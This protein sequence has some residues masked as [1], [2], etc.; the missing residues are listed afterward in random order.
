MSYR[1][2]TDNIFP[3]GT[4]ISAKANPDQK[5]IIKRYYQRIY[6]CTAVD[7]TEK[8]ELAY[9]QRELIPPIKAV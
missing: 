2:N 9:F 5:L 1:T 8:K 4:I 6:Y 3:E 7:S